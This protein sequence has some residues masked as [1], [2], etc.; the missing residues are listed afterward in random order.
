[1]RIL[2]FG[3]VFDPPHQGHVCAA[4]AAYD[5]IKPDIFYIIP[6]YRAPLKG[7][8]ATDERHRMNMCTLAFGDIPK[9]V[10]SDIE[11]KRGGESYTYLTLREVK[12]AHPQSEIFL[13]IGTDQLNQFEKWVQYEYILAH[14]TLCVAGRG[15]KKGDITGKNVI[16]LD[17]ARIDVSSTEIRGGKRENIPKKV[18]EYIKA[19]GLYRG[20]HVEGVIKYAEMIRADCFPHLKKED[21]FT[22]ASLHD[23]TK[24]R[25]QLQLFEAYGVAVDEDMRSSP[26]VMHAFTAALEAEKKGEKEEVINAI[27]YH[28]TGRADMTDI[29]KI[30]F[31]ADYIE[32]NRRYD[33]CVRMRDEY[34]RSRGDTDI[35][36]MIKQILCSTVQHL[37]EKGSF[38]HPLTLQA[39]EY[40]KK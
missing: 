30:I 21:V 7:G 20:N 33:H 1:M 2:I 8:A 37:E 17:N 11:I 35:N 34:L 12:D 6:A 38:I 32:E 28:T 31:I 16:F 40:Y 27:R 25:D 39:L 15:E 4:Q 3:G 26:A 5:Q 18:L 36:G 9:V 10:V 22:A 24:D 13:L 19:R 14:C 29:E 23:S